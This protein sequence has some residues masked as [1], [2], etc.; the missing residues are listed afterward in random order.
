MARITHIINLFLLF[1][2]TCL[3]ASSNADIDFGIYVWWAQ[4]DRREYF[5]K[6]IHFAMNKACD[7]LNSKLVN[8]IPKFQ[9]SDEMQR[10]APVKIEIGN[11]IGPFYSFPLTSE[12]VHNQEPT[13]STLG[14]I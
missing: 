1:S 12:N 4:C 3:I 5:Y 10:E 7:Q 9:N 11:F 13:T 8:S 2:S 14:Q 6:D